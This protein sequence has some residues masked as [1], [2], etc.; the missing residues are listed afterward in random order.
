MTN[1]AANLA[2]LVASSAAALLRKLSP[3]LLHA[4]SVD[5]EHD[6]VAIVRGNEKPLIAR[7]HGGRKEFAPLHIVPRIRS[8][9][10]A[11]VGHQVRP[12][13]PRNHDHRIRRR[14]QMRHGVYALRT[15]D[16]ILV[17]YRRIRRGG[18]R[19]GD[20]AHRF[21]RPPVPKPDAS[22]GARGDHCQKGIA[23]AAAGSHRHGM[24]KDDVIAAVDVGLVSAK[25]L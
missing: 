14:M 24:G 10:G 17:V 13:R 25:F 8:Q 7:T 16:G 2:R 19:R 5:I 22:V 11:R 18:Y 23:A 3:N 21:G 12:I 6:A 20:F 15:H 4:P 9:D 1:K